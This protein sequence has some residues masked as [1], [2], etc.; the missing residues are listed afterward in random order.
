MMRKYSLQ[1]N[2]TYILEEEDRFSDMAFRVIQNANPQRFVECIRYKWNGKEALAYLTEQYRS[3]EDML[4]YERECEKVIIIVFKILRNLLEIKE[5]GF[6]HIEN[7]DFDLKEIYAN[8]RT[9]DIYFVYFPVGL[10]NY[11]IKTEKVFKTNIVAVLR[12][13]PSLEQSD[14]IRTLIEYLLNPAAD[15][16]E[17]LRDISR[18]VQM[19]LYGKAE[20]QEEKQA[21]K[22]FVL[23]L[24]ENRTGQ[25]ILIDKEDMIL[26]RSAPDERGIICPKTN[27]TVGRQH[28]RIIFRENEY[29]LHDNKSINGTWLNN[30]RLDGDKDNKL[31][32]GDIIQISNIYFSVS[33]VNEDEK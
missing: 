26:G 30:K 11:D 29:Y 6:L 22:G 16:S 32:D 13:N 24:V 20:K 23:K 9:A 1:N 15:L 33:L 3:V 25:T 27:K 4:L 21:P 7:I 31:S 2:I 8:P 14:R 12:A 17:L 18:L 5:N 19:D 28:C 10:E